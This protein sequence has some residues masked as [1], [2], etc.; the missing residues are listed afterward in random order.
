MEVLFITAI[1]G[2]AFLGFTRGLNYHE[3]K[4]FGAVE[5]FTLTDSLGRKLSLSDFRNRVWIASQIKE[6]GKLQMQGKSGKATGNGKEFGN[7]GQIFGHAA[8][9]LRSASAK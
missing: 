4:S 3:L 6:N 2:I 9:S 1:A 8:E 7:L 5:S